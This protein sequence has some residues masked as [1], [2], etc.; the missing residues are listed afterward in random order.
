LYERIDPGK[1]VCGAGEDEARVVLGASAMGIGGLFEAALEGA[2]A[3]R[4]R[5]NVAREWDGVAA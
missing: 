1:G 2:I 3:G 5:C 4:R